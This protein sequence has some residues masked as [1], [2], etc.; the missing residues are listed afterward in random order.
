[1]RWTCDR[2]VPITGAGRIFGAFVLTALLFGVVAL[3]SPAAEVQKGTPE[4]PSSTAAV[5]GKFI[6]HDGNTY[7]VV[8]T[9][10]TNGTYWARGSSWLKNKDDASGTRT[11]KLTERRI[12]L[13]PSKEDGWMN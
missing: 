13:S 12:I 1:M 10:N 11:W 7:G 6:C 2:L 5:A 4:T 8:L 9:V 3:R